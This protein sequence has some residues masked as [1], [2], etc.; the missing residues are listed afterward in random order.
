[1]LGIDF[2][3]KIIE[4]TVP[5]PEQFE[6]P[7]SPCR[8]WTKMGWYTRAEIDDFFDNPRHPPPKPKA[9]KAFVT[10]APSKD[11]SHS[12]P[13][14]SSTPSQRSQELPALSALASLAAD[15]LPANVSDGGQER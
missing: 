6:A 15:A 14:N 8:D 5:A 10:W 12:T 7:T 1:M 13:S 9:K 3:R 2:E 11:S 4:Y